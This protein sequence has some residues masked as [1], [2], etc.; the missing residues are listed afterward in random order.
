LGC[1]I[2]SSGDEVAAIGEESRGDDAHVAVD[3]CYPLVRACLEQLAR[4]ELLERQYDA[5]LAPDTDC[6]AAVLYRLDCIFD[7]RV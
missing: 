4:D 1:L 5:V 6:C 2:A 7:L 3:R